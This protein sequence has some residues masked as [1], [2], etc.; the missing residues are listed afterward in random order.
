MMKEISLDVPWDV[1]QREDCRAGLLRI[2]RGLMSSPEEAPP[3]A[4]RA[5]VRE[6][7]SDLP[8]EALLDVRFSELGLTIEGSWL[9]A[10]IATLHEELAARGLTFRPHY[11]LSA[12]WF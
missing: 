4:P 5:V 8:D 9:E 10:R 3:G 7:W 11:W 6:G 1:M 12:E 2:Y